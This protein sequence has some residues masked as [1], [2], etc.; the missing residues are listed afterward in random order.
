MARKVETQKLTQGRVPIGLRAAI[1]NA[2]AKGLTLDM[3]VQEEEI[4]IIIERK[5]VADGPKEPTAGE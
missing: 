4:E 5:E 2:A 3:V 1:L